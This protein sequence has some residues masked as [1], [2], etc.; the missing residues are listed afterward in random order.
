MCP[1]RGVNPQSLEA[2][3]DREDYDYYQCNY[4]EAMCPVRG[5]NPQS[6]EA[7]QERKDYDY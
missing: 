4:L 5:V 3:Q 2:S 7:I 6:L 1:V